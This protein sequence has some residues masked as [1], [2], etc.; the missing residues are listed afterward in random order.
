M[1]G[2]LQ[3]AGPQGQQQMLCLLHERF[4]WP[5]MAAQMQ[6]AISSCE[7]CIQH[8]GIHVAH[9]CNYTFRVATCWLYQHWDCDGVGPT[10]PKH[11][12][13]VGLLHPLYKTH[14]GICD[15]QSNSKNCCLA[16]WQGYFL[17]FGALAKLLSDQGANFKSNIIR[18][19]CG[20]MAIWKVRT[21][22]YLA[23]TNGQVE[24]AHQTLMH[25]IGKLSKDQ[26][27]DWPRHLPELVHAYNSTRSAIAGYSPHYFLSLGGTMVWFLAHVWEVAGLRLT[28]IKTE[29]AWVEHSLA[30]KLTR[31]HPTQV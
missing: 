29:V 4:W 9:H 13:P 5:D 14:Y 15:P 25:M 17:I 6:K 30:F 1:N 31:L 16:L 3:D 23:E 2:C 7:Q 19:L 26:K 24:W 27:G 22:P 10:P 12:E 21:L 11:G 20:L 18:E 28:T 8:E